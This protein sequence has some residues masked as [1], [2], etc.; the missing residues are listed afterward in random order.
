M[1]DVSGLAG[2]Y[3]KISY[4]LTYDTKGVTQ[5]SI[6]RPIDATGQDTA[7]TEIYLGTC[8]RNVCTPHLGVTKISAAL[9][10]TDSSGK[11]SQFSKDYNL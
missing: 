7:S 1:L 9:E 6:G 10:F 11:K 4:E 2:K 3:T 5:G 8:S